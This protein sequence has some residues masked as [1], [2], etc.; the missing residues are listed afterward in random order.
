L[1]SSPQSVDRFSQ[2]T[3]FIVPIDVGGSCHIS[4]ID[5]IRH[6]LSSARDLL[7]LLPIREGPKGH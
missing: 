7:R 2:L 3:D 4:L 6:L 1:K 5:S